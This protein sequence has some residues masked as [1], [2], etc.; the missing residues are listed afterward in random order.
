M[1]FNQLKLIPPRSAAA[2]GYAATSAEDMTRS[3]S[4]LWSPDADQ[5]H[6]IKRHDLAEALFDAGQLT[7]A[8]L[9]SAR[10]V[11]AQ[12]PGR[13]MA[14]VIEALGIEETVIQAVVARMS[15]LEFRRVGV[16]D[17]DQQRLTR[18]G[19][20]F[21]RDSGIL[22]LGV[23]GNRLLLGVTQPDHLI[24]I[25]QVCHKL[26]AAA[27]LVV[28]CGAD[29][30]AIVQSLREEAAAEVA[31]DQ[32]IAGIEEDEVEVV[33]S[34]KEELDLERM[35]GESPVI[36]LVNYLIFNAIKEGASDIHVEPHEKRLSVRY[37]I[38][39]V[40]FEMMNPPAHMHAAIISRL[41][42][43]ANLDISERRLP[44][45]G[46]IRA[47]VHGRKLDLRLSTLP[48]AH[49]EKAVMRILD[50]RSIQVSL[51]DLGMDTDTLITWR[52]LV[53]SPHGILL[54]TGPTGSGKTT[55]LYSS[56][57]EMDQTRLNISTVE[58]PVEYHLDGINQ[59]QTH[60]KIGMNF[61]TALRALLRQDPDVIMLGEIRD[62]QTA[63]TAIQASLTGHLVL[64]TLHT[65]DAPSSVTRLINIGVEPFLVGAALN[66]ALAQRLVRRICTHCRRQVKPTDQIADHL[67][68]YGVALD[69]VWEGSGCERC[70]NTGYAGRAGIYE[71]LLLD[72]LLR[73]RIAGSPNVT[74]FRR[75]CKERGMVSLREDGFRKVRAGVTTVD[76]VMRVTESAM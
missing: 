67:A 73:D 33:E 62:A 56:I 52:R 31:F 37:R 53:A 70:R 13:P 75:V 14:Q 17:V 18:L 43:M 7:A 46:R 16:A 61:C 66:G 48:T 11:A 51:E 39:G 25:D 21:C 71:L 63:A 5:P 54:V 10:S 19:I 1:A 29:L 49:G 22:P 58:D 30:N 20:E 42:I 72:D 38:D 27:K 28:I 50:T 4:D 60:E 40:L 64:S 23:V 26:D 57:R 59:T 45:D 9:A 68:S 24:L 65:N 76:E 6:G 41:K 35:A 8:Q 47:M 34:K 36:R 15:G 69:E 32:I 55:T 74:E 44:Q 3:L 12:S 2:E